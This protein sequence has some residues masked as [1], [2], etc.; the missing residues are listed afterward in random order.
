MRSAP[1]LIAAAR[2]ARPLGQRRDA[3]HPA[4]P[5]RVRR[6]IRDVVHG[7]DDGIVAP[8]AARAG[9]VL[10]ADRPGLRL[11][12]EGR[13]QMG[14][15]EHRDHGVKAALVAVALLAAFCAA[16]GQEPIGPAAPTCP[17]SAV[18]TR[19]VGDA[20]AG[21]W[22]RLNL[23]AYT[24]ELYDGDTVV[25]RYGVAIGSLQYPTPIGDHFVA[26]VIWNPWWHPPESPWARGEPVM[27]PGPDNPMGKVKLQL[28][29][30]YYLHGT[31][32]PESV[33]R[34]GS[35]GCIRMRQEDAVQLATLVLDAAGAGV[36]R[37]TVDSLLD[38]PLFRTTR[39]VELPAPIPLRIVY[40]LAEVR[41]DSLRLYPDVYGRAPRPAR[42]QA[43]DALAAAGRD[44]LAVRREV[45]D[46]MVRQAR[47]RAVA[48]PLDSVAPPTPQFRR[49]P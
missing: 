15:P 29:G 20:P 22:L 12:T 40:E 33:G 18:D 2:V 23:P 45:L 46:A 8:R 39:D 38:G 36:P 21:T 5:T 17:T 19:A 10:P 43:L 1:W 6:H 31:P 9:A 32:W 11:G 14:M 48:A 7:A 4:A 49:L 13:R 47:R 27:A 41:G 3:P 30:S 16:G 42:G 26:R 34:A 25:R 35:H 37:A 44:T 28:R 24:L